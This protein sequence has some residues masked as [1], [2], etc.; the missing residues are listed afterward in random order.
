MSRLVQITSILCQLPLTKKNKLKKKDYNSNVDSI[1]YEESISIVYVKRKKR[2]FIKKVK[3]M[4]KFGED[5][6][7][8]RCLQVW[9]MQYII[10]YDAHKNI[11]V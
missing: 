10:F 11:F 4:W 1:L 5:V 3:K 7:N 6:V 2:T 9:E 8:Y